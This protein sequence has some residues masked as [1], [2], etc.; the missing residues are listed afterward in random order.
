MPCAISIV[1]TKAGLKEFIRWP[2]QLYRNDPLWVAP[3]DQDEWNTLYPNW[4]ENG[5]AKTRFLL[6]RRGKEIVGRIVGIAIPQDYISG[7]LLRVRWGWLEAIDDPE[8]FS[9]LLS[10]IEHWA[11]ALHA[12]VVQGPLGF[13]NLDKAGML[14][15]GFDALPTIVELYNPA[16]YPARVEQLGYEKAID[17]IEN[18]LIVP[19]KVPEKLIQLA[20]VIQNRYRV[21]TLQIRKT[22][23]LLPY[24]QELFRL[25]NETHRHLHGFVLF[26]E[27]NA[28]TYLKKYFRLVNKDLI[29]IVQDDR[30]QMIGYGIA[31]PSMSKA[32]QRAKGRLYPFGI[33]HIFRASRKNDRADLY[34]I[35]VKDEYRNKGI[36][37]LLFEKIMQG[38][39]DQGIREV[40][41][42]PELETNSQVQALWK[43]YDFVQHKR[44]RCYQKLL[45]KSL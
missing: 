27:A 33:W 39:I 26:D 23:E 42:N 9:A 30:D 35:G 21:K 37:A 31:I 2:H 8:V 18:K 22:A 36:T 43:N 3:L 16:Y 32:F 44:R 12:Q 45:D 29:C 15:K 34:L 1:N 25:I 40:E 20:R 7:N 38:F 24:G 41:S 6:A 17:W 19:G 28:A 11:S 4:K 5:S 10:A 14:I 13:T